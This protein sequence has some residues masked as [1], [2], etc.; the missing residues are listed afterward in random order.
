MSWKRELGHQLRDARK[1]ARL[2]QGQLATRLNVSRQ[3]ICRY[4]AGRDA[5]AVEVLALAAT[6]LGVE[7]QVLGLRINSQETPAR[8]PLRP[9][10][11]QLSLKFNKARSFPHA[12][13]RITPRK[14]RILITADIPA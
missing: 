11:R 13:V 4:E 6:T 7:F 1:A 5:P 8:P 12:V 14:G 10:P 3:M 9:L 2:T